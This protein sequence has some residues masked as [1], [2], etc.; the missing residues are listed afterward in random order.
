M[1]ASSDSKEVKKTVKNRDGHQYKNGAS[2]RTKSDSLTRFTACKI[3][4]LTYK[5]SSLSSVLRGTFHKNL[6]Q[7]VLQEYSELGSFK[8]Q[9]MREKNQYLKLTPTMSISVE[10]IVS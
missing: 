5:T 9:K 8:V 1:D 6:W 7:D 10:A 2:T 4:D 3:V